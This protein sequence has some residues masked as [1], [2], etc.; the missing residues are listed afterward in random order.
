MKLV[1]Y[2]LVCAVSPGALAGCS[3]SRTTT[4]R[5]FPLPSATRPAMP[6]RARAIPRNR[7]CGHQ[8]RLI[9]D[10]AT[11]AAPMRPTKKAS[12]GW[13]PGRSRFSIKVD[14]TGS[15]AMMLRP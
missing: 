6:T 4:D 2:A 14:A 1:A 11:T 5:G 10:M 15:S 7:R 13:Y 9:G 3:L 12:V 8:H